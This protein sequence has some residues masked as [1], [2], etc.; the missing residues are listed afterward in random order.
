[1]KIAGVLCWALASLATGVLGQKGQKKQPTAHVTYQDHSP[2]RLVYFDDST[3]RLRQILRGRT[4]SR[5][6]KD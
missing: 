6:E 4:L 1:M 5:Q 3:V 2:N